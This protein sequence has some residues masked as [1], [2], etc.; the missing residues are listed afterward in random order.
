MPEWMA[1]MDSLLLV[2]RSLQLALSAVF[3][4][5]IILAVA[6]WSRYPRPALLVVVAAGL[7]LCVELV[8]IATW[9]APEGEFDETDFFSILSSI[10][11]F[12]RGVSF[13]L[14]MLAAFIGRRLPPDPTDDPFD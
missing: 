6:F 9:T 10:D 7:S 14:L 1:T 13:V 3:L 4:A 8:Y 5:A 11:L 12:V 2:E